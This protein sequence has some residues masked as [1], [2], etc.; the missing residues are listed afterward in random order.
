[1]LND[2][3]FKIFATSGTC[4]L[5]TQ[6]GVPATK[7]KKIYEGRPNILDSITNGEYALIINSP[8]GKASV[9]DD[10]YLRKAAIKSKTPYMTTVAAAK[11]AAEGIAYLKKNPTSEIKSLQS[12]HNE[13]SE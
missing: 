13:I 8:I 9:H 7:V 10:S 5:I 4:D 12:L 2:N 3:G 11:I 1:I 6:A